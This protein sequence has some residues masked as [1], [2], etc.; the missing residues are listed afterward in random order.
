MAFLFQ[1]DYADPKNF[2]FKGKMTLPF[3]LRPAT[4]RN[5]ENKFIVKENF[6]DM[7]M[8]AINK[9]SVSFPLLFKLRERFGD[10]ELLFQLFGAISSRN[11]KDDQANDVIDGIIYFQGPNGRTAKDADKYQVA[12]RD[13]K[14]E[15]VKQ[16]L[17]EKNYT[18]TLDDL[19]KEMLDLRKEY[20]KLNSAKNTDGKAK[21]EQPTAFQ[22]PASQIDNEWQKQVKLKRLK[23]LS[24]KK[25]G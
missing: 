25:T 13:E 5:N 9:M 18:G 8:G 6:T 19:H 21:D 16:V 17:K 10:Q 24:P 14:R 23:D 2:N 7:G 11:L 3:Y 22:D 15:M 1:I 20:S 12:S 4:D